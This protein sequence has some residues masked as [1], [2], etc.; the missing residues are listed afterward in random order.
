MLAELKEDASI[1]NVR[2]YSLVQHD[3]LK[4]YEEGVFSS[5]DEIDEDIQKIRK[6]AENPSRIKL[7]EKLI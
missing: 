3:L 5:T 7:I 2:P 6:K 4:I 1:Q